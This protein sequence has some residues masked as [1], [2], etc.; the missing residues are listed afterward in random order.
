MALNG[1]FRGVIRDRTVRLAK[2]S[3]PRMRN[4]HV[5]IVQPN[6]ICGRSLI[7]IYSAQ[8]STFSAQ[9]AI[10]LLREHVP[11]EKSLHQA[12]SLLQQVPELGLVF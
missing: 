6:P 1:R 12:T 5:R 3:S 4:A 10:L 2:T 9:K 7:N 11:L 8:V